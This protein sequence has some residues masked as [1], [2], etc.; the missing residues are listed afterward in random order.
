MRACVRACDIMYVCKSGLRIYVFNL[1]DYVP[2][3]GACACCGVVQM[4]TQCCFRGGREL[5]S[6]CGMDCVWL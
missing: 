4:H 6:A 2:L 1:Y 3:E 5:G